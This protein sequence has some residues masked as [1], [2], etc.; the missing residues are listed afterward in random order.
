[1]IVATEPTVCLEGDYWGERD[2]SR[3]RIVT[4]ARSKKHYSRFADAERA[5]YSAG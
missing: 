2:Q 5:K 3:G 4:S 1:M